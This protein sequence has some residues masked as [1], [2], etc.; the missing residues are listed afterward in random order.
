MSIYQ[1]IRVQRKR[2][3]G[4][5]TPM[6]GCGCGRKAIY[7]GRGTMWGNPFVVGKTVIRMPGTLGDDWEYEGRLDA[8]PG[9]RVAFHHY[10]G[11]ITWHQVELASAEQ[12]VEMYREY[13]TG[14][15]GRRIHWPRWDYGQEIRESLAG[16]DLMCWC[17]PDQ[18][19]HADVLLEIARGAR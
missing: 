1:P 13:I 14:V 11:H 2:S 7:V 6:C 19:C 8:N 5:R 10:D 9:Q 3:A 15:R 4:W 18:P 17:G 12:C 16:H